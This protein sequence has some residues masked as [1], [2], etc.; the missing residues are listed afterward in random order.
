MGKI[1]FTEEQQIELRKNPYIKKVSAKSITYT[2]EF[3]EKFHEEYRAGKLPSQILSDMKIDPQMLGKRR[4][5]GFVAK[6]KIYESR[7]EGFEDT[8]KNHSG[9]PAT[10][11]LTD[12]EKIKHLE[13][14]I[15]YLNQENEFLKKNAQMDRQANWEYKRKHPSNTSSLKK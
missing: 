11:Q 13:R 10:K 12:I 1:Y 14:K 7:L 9:R 2:K 3:K 15:T 4:R 6:M 5:D 8:R